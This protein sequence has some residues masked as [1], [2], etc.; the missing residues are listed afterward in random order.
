MDETNH[1]EVTIPYVCVDEGSHAVLFIHGFLDSGR[2]WNSVID[3]LTTR[4]LQKVTLDLPGMGHLHETEGPFTLER[5][6]EVVG[7]VAASL[8][9]PVVI[10]GHSMGA[11]VAELVASA[12]PD[13]VRGL[14]LLTPVPLAGVNAPEE[15]VA[16]FKQLGGQSKAQRNMRIQL[17]HALSE[18][19]IERL[20]E[21]GENIKASVSPHLVDAWNNGHAR[22]ASHSVFSGPVLILRGASDPF[23]DDAMVA[24]TVPR[25]SDVR[26]ISI[27]AAGH[28]AHV[29]S[30]V[31]VARALDQ[32]LANIDWDG[33]GNQAAMNGSDTAG[34]WKNAFSQKT[35]TSFADAFAD[36]VILEASA[37]NEPV[38]GRDNV[39]RVMAAASKIY[40]SLTFTDQSA[41]DSRQ[42]VEWKAEAFGGFRLSGVT[43]LT[44]DE[45]GAIGHIAIHHRPMQG[46]IL[47]STRLGESLRGEIDS[48]HFLP[49]NGQK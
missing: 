35:A 31:S 41:P 3:S 8:G 38:V 34:D 30:P 20:Q 9:K 25:F 43:I 17:S 47:F 22:G 12:H 26:L 24:R 28:W 45:S 1:M 33:V 4:N 42:Y 29:E 40:E 2:I 23:V 19:D 36:D 32:Y 46:A 18:P 37:M 16:P 6:A 15:V 27:E 49:G 48:K 7:S 21:F 44:R 13:R 39:K 10:V 14:V 5:H 11:Q